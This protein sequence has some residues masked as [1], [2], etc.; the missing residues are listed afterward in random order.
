MTGLGIL[1]TIALNTIRGLLNGHIGQFTPEEL[2]QAIDENRNLWGATNS[3]IRG[4]IGFWKNRFRKYFDRY[5]SQINTLLL[6]EWLRQ[7]QPTLCNIIDKTAKN[8]MWFDNQVN[9]F[10]TEIR[11]I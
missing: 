1:E 6:L 4:K 5:I 8:Y 10:L 11:R 2:Q 3:D 9:D 7:D